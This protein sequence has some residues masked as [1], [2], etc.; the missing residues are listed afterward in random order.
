M[1][2]KPLISN[3]LA[4]AGYDT[5]TQTLEV[6]FNSGEIYQYLNVPESVYITFTNSE[7]PGRFFI[8][9]IKDT[10]YEFKKV[11]KMGLI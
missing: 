6:E 2:R 1:E 8:K 3:S 5:D 9:H 4:S 10:G 7:S 11:E